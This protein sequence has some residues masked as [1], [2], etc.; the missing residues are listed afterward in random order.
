MAEFYEC[1]VCDGYGEICQTCDEP[2][3]CCCCED[4]DIRECLECDGTGEDEDE[5]GE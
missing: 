2:G 5:D 4:S 3:D 1:P